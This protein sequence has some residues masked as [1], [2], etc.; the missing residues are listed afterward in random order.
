MPSLNFS[1]ELSEAKA[2]PKRLN[3]SSQHICTM[4]EGL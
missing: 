3:E 4:W 1:E 2:P